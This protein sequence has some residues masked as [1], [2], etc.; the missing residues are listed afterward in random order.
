MGLYGGQNVHIPGDQ[1]A[2]GGDGRAAAIGIDQL[3]G[4]PGQLQVLLEG[5]IGI[6][7]GTHA[8]EGGPRFPGQ[9]VPE[10]PKGI[11]LHP[12]GVEPLDPVAIAAAVTVQAPVTAPPVEV[13]GV[14]GA[15]PLGG[16]VPVEQ[17]L[18]GYGFHGPPPY[19]HNPLPGQPSGRGC[20]SKPV[21]RTCIHNLKRRLDGSFYAIQR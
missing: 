16:A 9:I 11:R 2:L 1:R 8:D 12:H 20:V 18:G 17:M 5:V 19:A 6:A 7:H 14:V 4:V 21:F 13:H 3:Q 10:N 15:E